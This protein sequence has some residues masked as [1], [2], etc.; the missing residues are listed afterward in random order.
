MWPKWI[1]G[2]FEYTFLGGCH[3]QTS[4]L[5]TNL[6]TLL[7]KEQTR[8]YF[9]LQIVLIFHPPYR[10]NAGFTMILELHLSGIKQCSAVGSVF[11]F[12]YQINR[13][14]GTLTFA[15]CADRSSS[16]FLSPAGSPGGPR[17]V[18]HSRVHTGIKAKVSFDGTS[19]FSARQSALWEL[20]GKWVVARVAL[21]AWVKTTALSFITR[22]S[23]GRAKLS[24][25]RWI[26]YTEV[27]PFC[28]FCVC[29]GRRSINLACTS[30]SVKGWLSM[31]RQ[32]P[33][34][35]MMQDGE[36]WR[37]YTIQCHEP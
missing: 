31:M 3:Q 26:N 5:K 25:D 27:T 12:S 2:L 6:Y 24:L 8:R 30:H 21:P 35:S 16:W 34:K 20:Q 10:T 1:H 18:K 14:G 23:E 29:T 7:R 28:V 37:I 17:L 4:R 11:G 33:G 9:F 32:R 36:R 13:F 19:Y 15:V 22:A